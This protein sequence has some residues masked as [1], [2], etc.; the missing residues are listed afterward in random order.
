MKTAVM[1]CE[2]ASELFAVFLSA[3]HTDI[4]VP[5]NVFTPNK[6][7]THINSRCSALKV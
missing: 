7:L 1:S 5:A 3:S 4:F 6:L 2:I